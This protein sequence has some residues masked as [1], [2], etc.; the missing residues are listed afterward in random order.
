MSSILRKKSV[1]PAVKHPR[2]D[3]MILQSP[4]YMAWMVLFD[5]QTWP[6]PLPT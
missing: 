1:P 2:P 3:N 6:S 4:C 5:F